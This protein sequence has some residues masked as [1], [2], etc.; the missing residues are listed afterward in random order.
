M[1]PSPT[2]LALS[3]NVSAT[4]KTVGERAWG[5]TASDNL[6][7][8]VGRTIG[9]LLGVL[10]IVF[11][12]LVVYAGFLYLTAQGEDAQVKKAKAIMKK[13]VIGMVLIVCS[14]AI[15]NLVTDSITAITTASTA[16]AK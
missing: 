5:T 11:L 7:L 16:A 6:P 14:Y 8:I 4:V 9:V 3:T 1:N 12:V 13:A 15:T 2:L 10:G